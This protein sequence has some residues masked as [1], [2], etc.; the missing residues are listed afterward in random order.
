M[1]VTDLGACM[2]LIDVMQ[3]N[4][5]ALGIERRQF[6]T[7]YIEIL[8]EARQD[9]PRRLGRGA[10]QPAQSVRRRYTLLISDIRDEVRADLE[11]LVG[12][13]LTEAG[14]AEPRGDRLSIN[15]LLESVLLIREPRPAAANGLILALLGTD[16]T[17]VDLAQW[18][19]E[20]GR[21]GCRGVRVG[22]LAPQQR[23]MSVLYLIEIAKPQP[24]FTPPEEWAA[25][26]A[27]VFYRLQTDPS[28]PFYI[29]WGYA[30]PVRELSRLYR[31]TDERLVLMSADALERQRGQ[32]G[33]PQARVCLKLHEADWR[34]TF[35]L[36]DQI[37]YTIESAL[38]FDSRTLEPASR[39]TQVSIA[40]EVRREAISGTSAAEIESK[41]AW[42]Q[43][44]IEQLRRVPPAQR[45]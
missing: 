13:R 1:A 43:Q 23:A 41:I 27:F 7:V 33:R 11:R 45:D 31:I 6:D 34:N 29:E 12:A 28:C 4:L 21:L 26:G 8:S 40:V 9:G 15:E 32:G 39:T 17:R 10:A 25:H 14:Q 24:N 3:R 2:R 36:P 42:H 22:C 16:P 37:D 44:T 38:E 5:P 20:L 35:E 30:H 18:H 19:R